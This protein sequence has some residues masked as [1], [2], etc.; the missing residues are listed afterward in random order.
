MVSNSCH[1]EGFIELKNELAPSI[2]EP[3]HAWTFTISFS[4]ELNILTVTDS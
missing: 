4:W 2:A 1:F 3:H